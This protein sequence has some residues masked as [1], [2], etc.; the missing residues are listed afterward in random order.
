MKLSKFL[1]ILFGW[2][3]FEV[4]FFFQ[5][6][7]PAFAANPANPN[8]SVEVKKLYQ[9]LIDLPDKPN[10]RVISG[11][12]VRV[13]KDAVIGYK[14]FV[15]V[16]YSGG[17]ISESMFYGTGCGWENF[18]GTGK[19]V[20]MIGITY[21]PYSQG[22]TLENI[23]KANNEVLIPFWN[24]GGLI[25]IHFNPDNPWT[26]SPRGGIGYSDLEELIDHERQS[27]AYLRWR[28]FLDVYA[29]G[30]AHLQENGVIAIIRPFAEMN[31][32]DLNWW[33]AGAHEGEAEP[34]I[35]L[36]KDMFDYFTYEKGLNNLLWVYGPAN[37]GSVCKEVKIWEN[38]GCVPIDHLYPGD[39]YVDIVGLSF[40][41]NDQVMKEGRYEELIALNKPFAFSE[42]GPDFKS[43]VV[44]C[45]PA[46][47]NLWDNMKRIEAIKQRY[48]KT[49][50]FL[51][52]SSWWD[53]GTDPITDICT[54]IVD[55]Q[56]PG[57]LLN[58]SWVIT[59]GELSWQSAQGPTPT[60]DP[61]SDDPVCFDYADTVINAGDALLW[62]RNYGNYQGEIDA[63]TDSKINVFEFGYLLQNWGQRC[64]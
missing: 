35:A 36:W 1:Q 51:A 13:E 54:A 56:N 49:V 15:D 17:N 23:V 8:A 16:L 44:R 29:A 4:F 37:G 34:F 32:W 6:L 19:W 48:P 53:W 59:R 43:D 55:T 33:G 14:E 31:Y 63:Y 50:Y 7:S 60:R 26:G 45:T 57:Q 62:S 39:N 22:G 10:K 9:Y 12:E 11:Q 42:S 27:E 21:G 30:L 25:T 46:S 18:A 24:Y 3:F 40:Y 38:G 52:W 20:A 61:S 28:Q 64:I 47:C 58:D 5:Q 2:I 41:S